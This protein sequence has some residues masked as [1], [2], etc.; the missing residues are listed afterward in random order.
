MKNGKMLKT[1]YTVTVSLMSQDLLIRK[2]NLKKS[3]NFNQK[4]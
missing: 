4:N 2:K 3:I 1:D